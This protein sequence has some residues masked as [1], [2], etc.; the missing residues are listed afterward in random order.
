[1]GNLIRM[2]SLSPL[3]D[4]NRRLLENPKVH[5]AG[6]RIPHPLK[7]CIEVRVYEK[8]AICDWIQIQTVSPEYKPRQALIDALSSIKDTYRS[9]QDQFEV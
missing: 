1:M 6:Y 7:L 3:F 8:R 2:Y 4:Q 9:L 5:Y